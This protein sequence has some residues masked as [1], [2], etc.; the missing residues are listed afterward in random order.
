VLELAANREA[1]SV[2]EMEEEK[3]SPTRSSRLVALKK[4]LSE[5]LV[6]S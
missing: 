3:G 2:A 5:R 6:P 1:E 4:Q